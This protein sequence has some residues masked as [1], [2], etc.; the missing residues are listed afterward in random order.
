MFGMEDKKKKGNVENYTYD[1]ENDLKDLSKMRKLK[2]DT[3]NNVHTLKNMLRQGDNK[4]EF[5]QAQI[6]LTG[7]LAVQKVIQ[8]IGR[9]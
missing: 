7:Y 2:E 3:E 6:L 9:K 5:D 4:E 8:R 1:L